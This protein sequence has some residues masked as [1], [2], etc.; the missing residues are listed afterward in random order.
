MARGLT[1]VVAV[2]TL[3]SARLRANLWTLAIVALGHAAVATRKLPAA[4]F[5]TRHGTS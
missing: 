4:A 1:A 2:P 3:R 5:S